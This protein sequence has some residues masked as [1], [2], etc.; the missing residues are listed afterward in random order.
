MVVD[1][2]TDAAG[3]NAVRNVSTT[4]LLRG[5]HTDVIIDSVGGADES[6]GAGDEIEWHFDG[7]NDEETADLHLSSDEHDSIHQQLS[8][9]VHEHRGDAF[10]DER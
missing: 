2:G 3:R 8:E 9:Y 4:V 1:D 7:L 10:E 5:M 6:V